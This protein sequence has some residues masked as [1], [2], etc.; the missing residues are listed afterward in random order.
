[1]LPGDAAVQV[2]VTVGGPDDVGRRA[3]EVY[4]RPTARGMDPARQRAAAPRTSRRA[5]DSPDE[6]R[7]LAAGGRDPG[8]G[9]RLVR[10]TGRA[11]YRYGPAFRGLRAAWR[12]GTDVFAEVALPAETAADAGAF[13]LHPALLDAALHA[14]LADWRTSRSEV[15]LPFAWT[16]VSL[17]AAGAPVLR[18]RLRRDRDGA[19][20]LV[21]AD[22][23]GLR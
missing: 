13:G 3:V 6:L 2:Q 5:A 4:A 11:G 12:R 15:Q 10:A 7:G 1:M 22:A 23:A 9:G 18:V 21:A 16:G 8:P 14:I 20:S 17:Y 19:L